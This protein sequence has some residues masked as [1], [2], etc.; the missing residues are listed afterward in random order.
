MLDMGFEPQ[1]R[2]IVEQDNMP[3][4][5]NRQTLMFS[6]TFPKEIQVKGEC[7]VKIRVWYTMQTCKQKRQHLHN[8]HNNL[9]VKNTLHYKFTKIALNN[10]VVEYIFLSRTYWQY[11]YLHIIISLSSRCLLGISCTITCS[12]LLDVLVAPAR[13]SHR[14]LYGWKRRI[15]DRSCWISSMEQIPQWEPN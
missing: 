2:R 11:L 14:K 12:W 9:N 10:Y 6:A 5:G 7:S 15:K 8:V 3:T 13:T 4:T 1:I